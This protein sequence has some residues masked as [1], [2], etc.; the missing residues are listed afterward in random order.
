MFTDIFQ[1]VTA[2]PRRRATMSSS[3]SRPCRGHSQTNKDSQNFRVKPPHRSF[4]L[5]IVEQGGYDGVGQQRRS[6][7]KNTISSTGC[8]SMGG[9][10]GAKA[11]TK[12][13]VGANK[14]GVG[15]KTG[16]T[17]A[18]QGGAV[19]GGDKGHRALRALRDGLEKDVK[20]FMEQAEKDCDATG[21]LQRI[22]FWR[23][24][25]LVRWC[26]RKIE[27]V[28]A[29]SRIRCDTATTSSRRRVLET[30]VD[31]QLCTCSYGA[32][33]SR[34]RSKRATR[35]TF[36]DSPPSPIQSND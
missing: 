7:G 15:A 22:L 1:T 31:C 5:A 17:G 14:A 19:G 33:S 11:N 28:W 3:W 24:C 26:W 21:K 30:H 25:V 16:G 2:K 36:C 8:S 9:A 35:D 10:R 6:Q 29:A 34:T 18:A 27:V 23:L 12:A 13:A 20:S 4:P 32:A